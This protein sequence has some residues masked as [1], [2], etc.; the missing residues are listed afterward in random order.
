KT[1]KKL[2]VFDKNY[3]V[4]QIHERSFDEIVDDDGYPCDNLELLVD[5]IKKSFRDILKDP[6]FK[7]DSLNF[8]AY[9]ATLVHLDEN[10]KVVTPLYN[11]LKPYPEEL[12]QNLYKTYGGKEAF[13]Q[14]TASPSLGMLNSVLQL[15][16]IKHEKPAL[17]K[18]IHHTLHFPQYLSFLFTGKYTTEK[19]SIGCHTAAWDFESH[20]YHDW[21]KEEGLRDLFPDIQSVTQSYECTFE[22]STFQ[23]GIG[24]H[25]SSAAL[26]PY[27]YT[28]EEPFL[29]TSTGTW[30]ITFN[31]FDSSQLTTQDLEKDCMYYM[32]IFGNRV[33]ASRLFLGNEYRHQKEK[34]DQ[35]FSRSISGNEVELNEE[36]LRKLIYSEDPSLKM[37]PETLYRSDHK[38]VDK[39]GNWNLNKFSSY[40]EAYHQLM[41][42]LVSHQAESIELSQGADEINKLI[43]T[44]GFSKNNIYLR[45]LASR[46]PDK[47]VYTVSQSHISALGAALV[48]DVDYRSRGSIKPIN[49]LRH[50][51]P[52][53]NSGIDAYS[54]RVG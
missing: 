32:N 22:G 47:K 30:C 17:F 1:N 13:M 4:L 37:E 35:H 16:W 42:D 20:D 46:F 28:L 18:K 3:S 44:G 9:G 38:E 51:D 39:P 49:N 48:C 53:P 36:L 6:Q 34:L 23:C 24:I 26:A 33:K 11:Y 21:I 52:V 54:S 19:T 40:E 41:I 7:V 12:E 8:S 27:L 14:K 43:I 25:D 5:W 50:H 10:G 15:Y 29:L 45:L 31:P 2:I